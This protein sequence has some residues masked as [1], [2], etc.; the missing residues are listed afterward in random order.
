MQKIESTRS[1]H[2][3]SISSLLCWEAHRKHSVKRQRSEK[4]REEI[5]DMKDRLSSLQR[6]E[7][8]R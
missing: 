6:G 4:L 1:Q 2:K 8:K 7:R 3:E 5:R